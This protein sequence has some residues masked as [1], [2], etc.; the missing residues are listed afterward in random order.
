MRLQGTLIEAAKVT[1]AQREQM[2]GL[3]HQ[4]Y[5]LVH[6]AAFE[7]DLA[8][9]DWVILLLD[10]QRRVQGFSTQMLLRAQLD[11]EPVT[12]LFSGDT[13]VH[14][15]AWAQHPLTRIWGRFALSLI[16]RFPEGSLYWFLITKGYKTYRFLPVFFHRFYPHYL[17][18]TP[19]REAAIL[20]RLALSKF[21]EDYDHPS[22]LI[23][24]RPGQSYRLKPDLG[25][26]T[27]QR[28]QDPHVA[29]FERSNPGHQLGEELCCLAP[30][31]RH[32]FT[33]A[34]YRA[35]GLPKLES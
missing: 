6:P 33:H 23:R 5:D 22:G 12:A 9:K 25:S 15:E 10:E 14:R 8:E 31:T 30:L 34:A 16:D 24:H 29:F 35:M 1:T 26:I 17:Q 18:P 27:P 19:Q 32:N 13:I 11:G 28:R 20:E 4:H 3:M 21:S 2:L 7:A